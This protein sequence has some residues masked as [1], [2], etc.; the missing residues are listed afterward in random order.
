MKCMTS[1]THSRPISSTFPPLLSFLWSSPTQSQHLFPDSFIRHLELDSALASPQQ[2]DLP[3]LLRCLPHRCFAYTTL[4]FDALPSAHSQNTSNNRAKY[5]MLTDFHFAGYE[6][7]NLQI[8]PGKMSN[9]Y[10]CY[11]GRSDCIY[12]PRFMPSRPGSSPLHLA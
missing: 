2:T 8:I 10:V 3:T 5:N 1:L 7:N 12:P 4:N 11:W 9:N 6:E